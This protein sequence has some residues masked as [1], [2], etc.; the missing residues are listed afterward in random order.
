VTIAGV[1]RPGFSG[2]GGPA[3]RAALDA[4]SGI[5]VDGAGDLFVADT[6]NCRVREIPAH[7][8]SAFGRTVRAGTIVT[9]TGGPCRD[10]ADPAPAALATD[11]AGDVFIA[12]PTAD[13]V[14]VLAPHT[15]TV[16]GVRVTAGKTVIV[17]GTGTAGSGG[18]GGAAVRAALDD[19]SGLVTDA[20]GDL[21]V[22]DTAN[23]RVRMVA[24]APGR[25]DGLWSATAAGEV[26]TVAGTGVCASSGDGGPALK[27]QVW[28]PGA[29]ATDAAGD[30]YVADQG[31]R[32]VRVLAPSAAMVDGVGVGAGDLATVAGEGSY[33]PYLIDGLAATGQTGELNFPTG[34]A[35][36][37]AGNVI[38]A[39]GYSH[40][41]REVTALAGSV[42]GK[43]VTAGVLVTVAGVNSMS[44]TVVTTVSDPVGV[45]VTARGTVVYADGETDVVR[46][47]PDVSPTG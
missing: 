34:L 9:L 46:A 23:C 4:P 5:A 36:D 40:A 28:D 13:R 37:R 18:D 25:R 38:V 20:A 22:A 43:A 7:D 39:D 47:V 41:I 44:G 6:G 27:A 17:A 11:A 14:D 2:D 21:F 10:H 45:A 31:N 24:A 8:G 32:T 15:G 30:L 26:S 33:G 3:D 29:L 12:Y 42:R 16:L 1:G 35:V 19:P